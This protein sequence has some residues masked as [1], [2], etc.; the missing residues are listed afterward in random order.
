M[1][2]KFQDLISIT[3]FNEIKKCKDIYS[4][5]ITAEKTNK[6]EATVKNNFQA[7]VRGSQTDIAIYKEE[8]KYTGIVE[9]EA[10]ETKIYNR[11]IIEI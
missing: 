10:M 7:G 8:N 4:K 11:S 9:L 2:L 3:K 1:Q 6:T 5:A